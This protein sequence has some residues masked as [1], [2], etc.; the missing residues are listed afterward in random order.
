LLVPPPLQKDPP[1]GSIESIL[2]RSGECT[3]RARTLMIQGTSS[4]VGKSVLTAALCR[5][6]ARRGLRVAPF[7]AQ[8]MALNSFVTATG[9]EM[10][11]AQVVQA[12]AAGREPEIEMNP[13]L[14][15]PEGD[16]RSQV[17]LMG[18]PWKTLSAGEYY[19]CREVL[20]SSVVSSFEK[21]AAENDLVLVEG[22]GSP[23]EINLRKSEIVNMRVAKTFGCPVLLAGD[24]DRGG[25]F[26]SLVGTLALLEE[27]ERALVK[28]FLINKFRGDVK[29][30]E[31]G[32]EMLTDLTGG[33]PVL[34]V[35][36]WLKNLAVAQEDSVY[37][38]ENRGVAEKGDVDIAVIKLPRISNY[39]DFDPLALEDGVGLRFVDDPASL[40]HPDA[41]IL[42]GSKT[43]IGDLAWLRRTGFDGLIGALAL[44]G[45]TVAG[46]CGGYQ[47]LGR[48]IIDADG[49]EGSPS[50]V[51]GLGLLPGETVFEPAKETSR[52]SGVTVPGP[53][54]PGDF[55]LPV[56][57]Y[58]IHMGKTVLPEGA[59]PLVRLAGGRTDGA[60][61]ARGR[62]WGTYLHGIFDNSSFRGAWLRSLG[63][64][65]KD[66]TASFA[67]EREKAFD[68]LA[69]EV[70]AS[71]DMAAL[72]RIIGL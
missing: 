25:V 4:S 35:I 13:V 2:S 11:R 65:G 21:L 7:K 53:G 38:D 27:D 43:T 54:F 72:E 68:R 52:V 37:L 9:E 47:M 5:I 29:L 19:T 41:L 16:S 55:P 39:D 60:V 59:R 63:W 45:S 66:S 30:L 31:P 42:P 67:E 14:L 15:K 28:G 69:D 1:V 23:A 26:A 33:R 50:E 17:V 44:A 61:S 34:G 3:I 51:S 58:E 57:G 48:R 10:G 36:P 12:H 62:V 8:N 24:I 32:L 46:I 18:R 56:E 70:E 64:K 22:A 71:L 20:W 49:V 40:G 6:F